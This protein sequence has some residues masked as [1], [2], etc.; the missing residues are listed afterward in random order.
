MTQY[1]EGAL[2]AFMLGA[3]FFVPLVLNELEE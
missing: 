1:L 2:W 3:P